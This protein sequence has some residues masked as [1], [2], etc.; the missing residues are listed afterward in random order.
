MPEPKP[1]RRDARDNV[2][3]LRSAALDVFL[4]KGLEAPLDEIAR[5]A[6]VSIGTL[7]NRF[8]SREA[9]IDAVIPEV[10][11]KRLRALRTDV[12][13]RPTARG[14]LEAFVQ[15]MI[16]LQHGDPALN[17]AILQRYPDATALRG[18]C[19]VSATLGQEL[20]RDAHR[21]G[22]LSPDFTENDLFCL[23]WL[24]GTAHRDP[25][26]PHGWRRVLDHALDSAWTS[27]SATPAH[28]ASAPPLAH[29]AV[30]ESP[31]P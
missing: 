3:K 8:G 11:G 15:G 14:R 1:L 24:A 18:V 22:S 10:A 23:L 19:D 12:M 27:K 13:A 31:Q 16:D 17:D 7:Y 2:A 9:L 28:P 21:E 4:M 20:V 30:G 5:T 26:A 29:E 6:G 25:A